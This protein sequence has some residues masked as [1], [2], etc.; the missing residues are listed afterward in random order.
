MKPCAGLGPEERRGYAV[1]AQVRLGRLATKW[2]LE[3]L[4]GGTQRPPSRVLWFQSQ[5]WG[6]TELIAPTVLGSVGFLFIRHIKPSDLG[7]EKPAPPLKT[8]GVPRKRPT[9]PDGQMGPG[10]HR[11]VWTWVSSWP[12]AT[13]AG[14]WGAGKD[15]C[16]SP[17]TRG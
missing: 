11:S 13:V 17:R 7:R 9:L 10:G 6:P 8:P 5:G 14:E 1:K 4:G 12:Q 15:G 2:G 16:W 3:P